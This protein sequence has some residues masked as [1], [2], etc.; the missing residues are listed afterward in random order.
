MQ[1]GAGA[2]F[3][4]LGAGD[5]FYAAIQNAS[6]TIEFVKVTARVGDVMTIVRAQGGTAAIAWAAGDIFAQRLTIETFQDFVQQQLQTAR[7]IQAIA[8]TNTIT[9]TIAGLAAYTTQAQYSFVAA[10]TNTGATTI[11]ISGLGAR[12]ILSNGV[13]LIGGELLIGNAYLLLDNGTQLNLISSSLATLRAGLVGNTF[14]GGQNFARTSIVQSTAAMDLFA[15]SNTID[16]TGAALTVNAIVNAPQAGAMRRFYGLSGTIWTNNAMFAIDGNAN[17]T[18]FTGDYIDI[19]AV[20]VSTYKVHPFRADGTPILQSSTPISS[21][22]ANTTLTKANAIGQNI[23]FITNNSLVATLPA[24]NTL[25]NGGVIQFTAATFNNSIT[26][27]GADNIFLPT[28]NVT[29]IPI[30]IGSMIKLTSDGVSLW[31]ADIIPSSGFL[32]TFVTSDASLN[33]GD[34]AIYD[35]TAQ[36]SMALKLLTATDQEYEIDISGT[37]TQVAA[38]AASQ[39][40]W[41]NT[42]LTNAFGVIGLASSNASAIG[43]A[44]FNVDSGFRLESQGASIYAA[45]IRAFTRTA[46]KKVR[47]ESSSSTST[48]ASGT[49]ITSLA[50][51]ITTIWSSLGTI[52][53]PNS[54]TGRIRVKRLM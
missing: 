48:T 22:T 27:A 39:L 15:L 34:T 40:Q 29:S 42:A 44:V 1:V 38:A 45:I 50:N 33:V 12:S 3:P 8:G 49:N 19:E 18:F 54:W 53:M 35:F 23:R 36:T 41:N 21:I 2:L 9:G 7:S 6:G 37:F 14:T 16:G 25:Q 47:V 30:S 4:T 52:V 20:T 10:A 24:A 13:A 28:G 17:F 31:Y 11:N 43:Q 51:D 26:R 46:S 32:N 5:Y